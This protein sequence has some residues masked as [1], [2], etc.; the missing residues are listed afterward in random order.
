MKEEENL[1]AK[2]IKERGEREE[3]CRKRIE[4]ILIEENCFLDVA[5]V[6]KEKGNIFSISVI[7]KE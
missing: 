5:V 3:R 6:L 2:L 1:K 7:S 4:E